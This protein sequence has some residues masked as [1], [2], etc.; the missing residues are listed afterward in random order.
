M[1][2]YGNLNQL[3]RWCSLVPQ[4]VTAVVQVQS[5][6]QEILYAAGMEYKITK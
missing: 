5:L 6:A 1:G 4:Q 3:I 2:T